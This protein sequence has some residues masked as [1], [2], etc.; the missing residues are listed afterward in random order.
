M[1]RSSGAIV[2]F[3]GSYTVS[4]ATIIDG[5]SANFSTGQTVTLPTLTLSSGVLTGSDTVKVTGLTT[6]TGGLMGGSGT[7]D[8]VGGLALG[9]DN[10][11]LALDTRTLINES[12]AVFTGAGAT[13]NVTSGAIIN[14]LVGAS[15]SVQTSN[16]QASST[17]GT[18]NNA[19]SVTIGSG[20]IFTIGTYTQT[21]G[22]TELDGGTL[23]DG[24]TILF[25]AGTLQGSGTLGGNVT[26][27]GILSP[28]STSTAGELSITGGYTQTAG[29]TL[30]GKIG[31]STP[32]TNQDQIQVSGAAAFNGTLTVSLL[33]GFQPNP[34]AAFQLVTFGSESGD[35]AT[36]NGFN[37]GSGA[38]FV[39]GLNQPVGT[40]TVTATFPQTITFSAL[41]SVT[42]A[43]GLTVPLN[44]TGGVSGNAVT[45][46]VVSGPGTISGNTLTVTGAGSIV[47]EADQA[48]STGY[49]AATAVQQTLVVNR[50]ALTI[51]ASSQSKVYGQTLTFGS[52]STLFTSNGLQNT[53]S[54]GSVTLAVSNNGGAA[55]AAVGGSYTITPQR[56]HGRH[57]PGKQ[58]QYHLQDKHADSQ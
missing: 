10:A 30:D 16:S 36:R 31:G 53:D 17:G 43:T 46:Q 14:N 4:G 32:G 51:T 38:A 5:G 45:F 42:Y 2:A 20:A 6:W 34:G 7:T 29:G 47:I 24:T 15:W 25:Q 39:E 50:A 48:A 22:V 3:D 21:A 57:L 13:L 28:G 35:F 33:N 40:L 19:G 44:A 1:S 55:T 23:G 18:F 41:T 27:S 52:G 12:A 58:L 54:I 11:T 49:Y 56:G 9:Q 26:N 8:A 37:L